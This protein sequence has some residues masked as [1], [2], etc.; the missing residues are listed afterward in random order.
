MRILIVEDD[1][2]NRKLLLRVLSVYGGCE[3][4]GDGRAA[5]QAFSRALEE[6]DGYGLV[7]LDIMLP[8][9]DGHETLSALRAVESEKGIPGHERSRVVMMTT[10]GDP[11]NVAG[12]FRSGCDAYV[13]KP[14]GV[15]K[16]RAELGKLGVAAK[17]PERQGS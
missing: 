15:G 12:A 17:V 7:F 2:V 1:C 9:T 14:L 5:V 16:V 10:L 3:A 11:G 6:G 8:G 13:L 4:V